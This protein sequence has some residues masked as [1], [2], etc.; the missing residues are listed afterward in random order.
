MCP[1][2]QQSQWFFQG[3][4]GRIENLDEMSTA[5]CVAV[6]IYYPFDSGIREVAR[7]L[8]AINADHVV[9]INI[10]IEYYNGSSQAFKVLDWLISF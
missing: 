4:R 6:D 8:K 5:E 7:A 9:C 3:F 1:D 10:Y 2:N